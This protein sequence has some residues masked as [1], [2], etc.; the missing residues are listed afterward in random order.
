M[1][2]TGDSFIKLRLKDRDQDQVE[3]LVTRDPERQVRILEIFTLF[4]PNLTGRAPPSSKL[5]GI[6]FYTI[7][8]FPE[9]FIEIRR[10]SDVLHTF[11]VS[12]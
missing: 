4:Q 5:A 12:Y 2:D 10:E 3:A 9:S 11:K 7:G 8:T 6:K 1:I